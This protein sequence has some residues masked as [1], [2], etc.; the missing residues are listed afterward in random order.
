MG[1]DVLGLGPYV[2]GHFVVGMFL[3][4]DVLYYVNNVCIK[5]M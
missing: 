3:G 1:W 5:N 2:V 4:W